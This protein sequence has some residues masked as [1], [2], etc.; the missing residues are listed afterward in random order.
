MLRVNPVFCVS[1]IVPHF[2]FCSP[3]RLCPGLPYYLSPL[4]N[5]C[6]QRGSLPSALYPWSFHCIIL[7]LSVA[8]LCVCLFVRFGFS[9]LSPSS[10]AVP[11]YNLASSSPPPNPKPVETK[12][13]HSNHSSYSYISTLTVVSIL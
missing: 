13:R 2:T 9:A 3:P 8:F 1:A 6:Q 11:C 10:V 4:H 5:S 7:C 12:G